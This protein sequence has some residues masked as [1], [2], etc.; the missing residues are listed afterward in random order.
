MEELTRQRKEIE[1]NLSC[2]KNYEEVRSST[3]WENWINTVFSWGMLGFDN[4]DV[5]NLVKG[6][7]CQLLKIE[8]V[9][10]AELKKRIV[11][12][13][14]LRKALVIG[15]MI[16]KPN[17][18]IINKIQEMIILHINPD[19]EMLIQAIGDHVN[20]TLMVLLI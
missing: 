13:D 4:A 5:Y 14:P 8:A 11:L 17:L 6:G 3:Y 15:A 19:C 12:I 16:P 20:Y 10:L 9:T 1:K 7:E 18:D 2:M